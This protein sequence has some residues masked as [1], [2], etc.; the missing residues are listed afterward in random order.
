M[1]TI[2]LILFED[3]F[4][5]MQMNPDEPESFFKMY[6]VFEKQAEELRKT[7]IED[8]ENESV[9]TLAFF[10]EVTKKQNNLTQKQEKLHETVV[11][12]ENK[13]RDPQGADS[14]Q[15]YSAAVKFFEENEGVV[16][17]MTQEM[18]KL[19]EYIAEVNK[20]Q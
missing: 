5:K 15:Q 4:S 17:E 16:Q 18:Q 19:S 11:S 3:N 10:D 2:V 14:H 12:I 1:N 13:W 7:L 6:Y 8:V 20:N 9:D